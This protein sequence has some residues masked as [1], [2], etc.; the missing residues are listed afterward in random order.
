M[1]PQAGDSAK[2]EKKIGKLGPITKLLD[3]TKTVEKFSIGTISLVNG[4]NCTIRVTCADIEASLAL[5]GDV[6]SDTYE[7]IKGFIKSEKVTLFSILKQKASGSEK[8]FKL[9]D[10]NPKEPK[11]EWHNGLITRCSNESSILIKNAQFIE[12]GKQDVN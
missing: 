11:A 7:T 2:E 3:S 4:K 8:I 12:L 9:M 10:M 1:N 5:E 6:D